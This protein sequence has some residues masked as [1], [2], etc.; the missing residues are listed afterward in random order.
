M[1]FAPS[2]DDM[3]PGGP[4]SITL[5]VGGVD[6]L[7]AAIR[8]GH[9]DGVATVVAKLFNLAGSCR[10]Y[11]GEKDWQQLGVVRRLVADLSFGVQVVG[12]PTVRDADG[13]AC[14]SRNARLSPR[15]RSAAPVVYRALTTAAA[16]MAAGERNPDVVRNLMAEVVA[17]EPLATLDYAGVSDDDG[18]GHRLLVA[19][20]IGGTRLIDNLGVIDSVGLQP[21][22]GLIE[23][24]GPGVTTGRPVATGGSG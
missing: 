18:G 6:T 23:P 3:Y 5:H 2:V 22:Y 8:P 13:V 24:S 12:C 4:P 14:S 1:V 7:E 9:F 15:E 17:G 16:A 19:A 10:A 11:F 21:N 20:R